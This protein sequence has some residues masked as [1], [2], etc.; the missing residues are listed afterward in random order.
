MSSAR[1]DGAVD[2]TV[3]SEGTECVAFDLGHSWWIATTARDGQKSDHIIPKYDPE[4]GSEE[5]TDA[6][7]GET[8]V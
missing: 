6:Q 2:V 8:T 3:D 7:E 5:N 4:N 1:D